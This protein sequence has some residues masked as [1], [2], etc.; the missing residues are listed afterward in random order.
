MTKKKS[1]LFKSTEEAIS[2]FLG[3]VIVLVVVGLIINFL[4]GRKKGTNL[5][6]SE[7]NVT[8]EGGKVLETGKE[9]GG[10]YIVEKGDSLWK[11]AL[12]RYNDGYQWVEIAKANNLKNVGLILPGQKLNL[13]EL[14]VKEAPKAMIEGNEYVVKKGDCLWNIAIG[15]YN[16]GYK[17]VDIF[18]ANKGLIKNPDYIEIGMKLQLP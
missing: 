17:W 7:H 6:D 3:L 16:D 18:Q 2:M 1:R 4:N 5:L 15:K 13:P 8:L 14:A 9:G 10:E 11:I 12:K